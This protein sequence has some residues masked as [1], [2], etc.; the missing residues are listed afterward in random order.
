VWRNVDIIIVASGDKV[1][2]GFRRLSAMS[3]ES[4]QCVGV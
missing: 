2:L 1:P 4:T 3:W